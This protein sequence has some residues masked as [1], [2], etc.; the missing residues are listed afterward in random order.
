MSI[1]FYFQ[2]ILL[3]LNIS[4]LKVFRPDKVN[5]P[6]NQRIANFKSIT[7]SDNTTEFNIL[8]L[9]PSLYLK[10]IIYFLLF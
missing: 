7:L 3:M 8:L 4:F 6:K 5:I 10:Y 2:S 9:D 1:L